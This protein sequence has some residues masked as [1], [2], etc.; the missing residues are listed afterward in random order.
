MWPKLLT[1]CCIATLKQI[2][3][4]QQSDHQSFYFLDNFHTPY[5]KNWIWTSWASLCWQDI[6][7]EWVYKMQ[8]KHVAS[9][10]SPLDAT[11]V[12]HF[13]DWQQI[14]RLTRWNIEIFILFNPSCTQSC[15][16][17]LL[18]L[19]LTWNFTKILASNHF[20]QHNYF[21]PVVFLIPFLTLLFSF[22]QIA[23]YLAPWMLI[24]LW[25]LTSCPSLSFSPF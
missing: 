13:R 18:F 2:P 16:L 9:E 20:F 15:T 24:Y 23:F 21:L 10:S 12:F 11:S 7:C 5:W 25:S 6:H 3:A 1:F 14:D 4:N 17:L 22:C 19:H 8:T